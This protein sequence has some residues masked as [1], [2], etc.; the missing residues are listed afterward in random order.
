MTEQTAFW[1]EERIKQTL[2]T[3]VNDTPEIPL[4]TVLDD[5]YHGR[6]TR[7]ILCENHMYHDIYYKHRDAIEKAILYVQ[8]TKSQ[9]ILELL[10][11]DK[12]KL[13]VLYVLDKNVDTRTNLL[14]EATKQFEN[15]QVYHDPQNDMSNYNQEPVILLD[16]YHSHT[17]DVDDWLNVLDACINE[18]DVNPENPYAKHKVLM[19][20]SYMTP[21]LFF[22]AIAE[23]CGASKSVAQTIR[24]IF[25]HAMVLVIEE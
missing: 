6:V 22:K 4:E 14:F 16:E 7:K 13:D 10:K 21:N 5:I 1:V 15:H 25:M 17:M 8:Q 24:R 19:V 23:N 2:T 11:T 12:I 20:S 3:T 9:N 18:K